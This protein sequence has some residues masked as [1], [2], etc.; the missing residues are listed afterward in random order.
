[1]WVKIL[2]PGGSFRIEESG[3]DGG[4]ANRGAELAGRLASHP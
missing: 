1:M 4:G 2:A 3:G